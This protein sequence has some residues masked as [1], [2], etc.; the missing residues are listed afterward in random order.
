MPLSGMKVWPL[1]LSAIIAGM[2]AAAQGVRGFTRPEASVGATLTDSQAG[3]VTLTL[4]DAAVR[5]I[6]TWVRAS[7]AATSDGRM[8]KVT[9]TEKQAKLIRAGQRSR[10]Y[11]LD[12]RTQMQQGQVAKVI[13]TR[14][15][16]EVEIDIKSPLPPKPRWLVDIVTEG[17]AAL[18]IPNVSIIEEDNAQIVYLQ[19]APGVYAARQIKTG[20]QGELYT[21]VIEG[22]TAGD[23]VVSVG[24]FFVDAET[25]LKS[26]GGMPSMPGMDHGS[27][28]GMAGMDHSGRPVT[29]VKDEPGAP[30][31]LTM[32]EPA[33][34]SLIATP[35]MM[36][37]VMFNRPVDAAK[38]TMTVTSGGKAVDV[39]APMPMGKDSTMLMVMPASALPSG[40]YVVKWRAIGLDAKTAEGEFSF[41][42]K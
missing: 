42:V 15:G 22:L 31:K 27:M 12:S 29:P 32:T 7:G 4:T 40:S 8:L 14:S 23:Q 9:V 2:P 35:V 3:D 21:Q 1:V 33:A 20:V 10:V 26:T 34:S 11:A 37:H 36:I 28:P 24:S 30:I 18:S 17:E 16:A 6:Q 38:S 19:T 39:G 41:T 5:P 25:K 13:R